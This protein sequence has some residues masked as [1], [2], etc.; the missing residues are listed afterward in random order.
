MKRYIIRSLKYLVA[1]TLL[2][3]GLMWLM[4]I[5]S[6]RLITFEQEWQILFST[7]RGWMMVG[8]ILA[9]AATYPLFGFTR[10]SFEGSIIADR[11]EI[12]MAAEVVGL[13]LI[14]QNKE[15]L[16]YRA[17]GIRRLLRLFEDEIRVRQNG[18]QIEV[19]GLRSLGVRLAFDAERYIVNKH[20]RE[21]GEI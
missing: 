4:H 9:L 21:A 11:N 6:S 20:R 12:D 17:R 14:S 5:T 18:T 8:G 10:R 1:L 19:V 7:W 16:V 15:E 13:T 3:V 2:Y